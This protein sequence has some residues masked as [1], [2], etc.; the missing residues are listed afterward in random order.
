MSKSTP[1]AIPGVNMMTDTLDFFKNMWESAPG[2][3]LPGMSHIPG[4]VM[5]T[6][7]VDEIDKQIK[8]LKAVESWLSLN[9]NML[10][11]TIQ[12]LE[13]QKATI[14]T[15][16]TMGES[17]TAAMQTPSTSAAEEQP[18]FVSPFTAFTASTAA[19]K[20]AAAEKPVA[21]EKPAAA[22]KSPAQPALDATAAMADAMQP[23]ANP[24]AWWGM[25][26]D[27][28]KQA[29]DTAAAMTPDMT[30]AG[31]PSATKPATKSKAATKAATEAEAAPRKRK[32]PSKE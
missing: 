6:L 2:M 11:T 17:F 30:A 29:V 16:Q 14:S 4:M 9:L 7:S 8:D 13:V 22:E 24:A 27:Q 10:H 5:P 15:L 32:S 21:S 1:S 12:A 31:A 3:N 20:S 28:F 18:A 19:E 25:L 23:L 26:Q